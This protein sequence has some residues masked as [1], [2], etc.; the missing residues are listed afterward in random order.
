MTT[1]TTRA[2]PMLLLT[3][4]ATGCGL[5]D[6]LFGDNKPKHHKPGPKDPIAAEQLLQVLPPMDGW[7]TLS[8]ESK[9]TKVGPD[10]VSVATA[11]YQKKV[12]DK[13]QKLDLQVMD[14]NYVSSVYAP[15]AL[16]AHSQGDGMD[17]H[18]MRIEIQGQPGLEEWKPESG[19]VSVLL[20]VGRRF[21]IK[22]QG[23]GIPP[24]LVKQTLEATDVQKL[25][26]WAAAAPPH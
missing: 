6:R 26:T 5:I 25:A 21:V 23:E 10:E 4:F 14:G 12:D 18:K 16:M 24:P 17:P 11:K 9:L 15:F 13:L 19:S 20:L 22:L 8:K 2:A 7:E 3:A 1:M